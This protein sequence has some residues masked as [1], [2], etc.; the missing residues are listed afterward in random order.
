M[1][2]VIHEIPPFQFSGMKRPSSPLTSPSKSA[3]TI[4]SISVKPPMNYAKVTPY[5][6]PVEVGSFSFD[7]E[8][9][10]LLHNRSKLV[11]SID[12]RIITVH[13]LFHP[14][15]IGAIPKSI[16]KGTSHQNTWMPCSLFFRIL[17]EKT[18]TNYALNFALVNWFDIGRGIMTKLL[19]TP[20]AN[21][22]WELGATLHQVFWFKSGNYLSGRTW[23][24]K[25]E[26]I[27]PWTAR[28]THDLLWLQIR[29]S[30]YKW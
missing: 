7:D 18:R 21:E 3:E 22:G 15:W 23:G 4:I 26:Q 2:S 5:Q 8:R 24:S 19:C 20:Y 13:P 6:Q 9:T 14:I 12:N 1:S 27:W 30:C 11:S 28:T 29:K 16:S 10:L 25:S 17:I